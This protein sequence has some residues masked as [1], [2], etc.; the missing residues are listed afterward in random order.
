MALSFETRPAAYAVI[1]REEQ[2]LLAYWSEHGQQAWTMPG[3]GLDPGEHP[4]DGAIREV[5]EETGYHAQIDRM[6]GVDVGYWPAEKR[7]DGSELPLQSLRFL[8]QGTITGGEL[9]A[10]V[11]GTTTHAAWIPLGE[12]AKLNRVA[13]VDVAIKLWLQK[14]EDGKLRDLSL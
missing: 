5:F 11:N 2:I 10:E 9:T 6:L 12:V 1:V 3:G 13:L 14:P 8:Y 4:V 7:L